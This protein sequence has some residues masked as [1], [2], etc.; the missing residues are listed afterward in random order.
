MANK[1][2]YFKRKKV[3]KLA[4]RKPLSKKIRFE[5]FKRD[6][7]T[8]QYC[9]RMAPDVILEVDHIKPVAEGGN[10]GMLNLITSCRDCNRG[11]GKRKISDNSE[12]KK[13]QNELT[14]LAEKREQTEMM[15]KWR[16][17]LLDFEKEKAI[18]AANY[19]QS[20]TGFSVN[21]T[22]MLNLRKWIRE[23]ELPEV[24]NA[25]E[26]AISQYFDETHEGAEKAFN[27]IG[28]ICYNRK[29]NKNSWD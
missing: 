4:E 26:I 25:I 22:G 9:G 27:K 21:E 19:F 10:N 15:M 5:V 18:H 23:F 8:C 20:A 14:D 17:S 13:Q 24:I 12:L 6:K 29:H 11:K 3:K 16:E 2:L 28:G 1:Y 7:F